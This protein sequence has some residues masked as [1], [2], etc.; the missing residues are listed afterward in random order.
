MTTRDDDRGDVQLVWA[1]DLACELVEA[2]TRAGASACDAAVSS[3]S[4]LS[5]SARDGEIEDVSRSSSRAAGV[6]VIVDG[7]LGFATSAD[8]PHDATAVAELARTAVQLARMST[9][10][11]NN[12]IP[13]APV[14]SI[15]D[16]DA[17]ARRLRMFDPDV[18]S[19]PPS[20][21]ID[22]ALEMERV[23]R[24]QAGISGVRD[25]SAATRRGMFA[26]ATSTGFSGAYHGTSVQL[27]ASGVVEDEGGKKQIES[28]WSAG[29]T[30]AALAEPGDVALEAARRALSRKGA[31]KVPSTRAPVIF[32]PSMA[33]GFLGAVLGA[34]SGDAIARKQSFLADALGEVVWIAGTTL[35]DEPHLIGGLGSRPFDGE[36]LPTHK[37]TL[38]DGDGRACTYLLD[39]RS[40]RR[41]GMTPTGHAA[42]GA[43]SL[44]GPSTSNVT[45]AGG[46]GDLASLV[47]ETKR[48]LLVTRLLGHSP[49]MS[50][51]EYSRGASGFWIEDGAIAFPVEEV[52]IAGQMRE[53]MRGIDRV[54]ADLDERSSVRA[55]SLRFAELAISGS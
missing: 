44:P 11:D 52:T 34:L 32:D 20:W 1:R 5:A 28:W 6:R 2:A 36:G 16:V 37:T 42:R 21:A 38:I 15:A 51:G 46:S 8:A 45:L 29:R 40:A 31:R 4:S 10:S 17:L 23:V 54:G 14:V 43:T 33:R 25:V 24:A 39:A 22:K 55:P 13:V 49:Q 18:A 9:P 7:R 3:G 47:R 50:T 30:F 48:G 53:M 41:L 26:L 12:V 19:A 27:A 35:V